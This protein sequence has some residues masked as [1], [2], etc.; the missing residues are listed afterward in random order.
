MQLKTI[1]TAKDAG[2]A[3][4]EFV[5]TD[6]AI[7][8]VIIGGKLRIRKGESYGK[9]LEVLIEQPFEEAKRHRATAKLDGFDPKITY[10]DS[11][12]DARSATAS[13]PSLAEVTIEE[14]TVYL[15]DNGD[16]VGT[17]DDEPVAAKADYFA[18]P[19]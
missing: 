4:I 8:E 12:Y 3:G 15:D 6:K 11:D 10:H 13:M 1:T 7:T 19:F 16:V 17:K 18:I 14:V 2:I 5:K 9:A